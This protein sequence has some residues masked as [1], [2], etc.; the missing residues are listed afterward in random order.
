MALKDTVKEALTKLRGLKRPKPK[1]LDCWASGEAIL[2]YMKKIGLLADGV[3]LKDF[4]TAMGKLPE[5]NNT[6]NTDTPFTWIKSTKHYIEQANKKTNASFYYICSMGKL[7][8]TSSFLVPS[9][10]WKEVY[11][12]DWFRTLPE[13]R[14]TAT[15][16]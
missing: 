12:K 5:I 11:E 16:K 6:L 3:R 2:Q 8:D 14:G 9:S 10:G 7:L 1:F 4:T 13:R 15:D